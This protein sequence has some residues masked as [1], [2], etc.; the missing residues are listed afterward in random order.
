MLNPLTRKRNSES[1]KGEKCYWH[2]KTG[3]NHSQSKA[4]YCIELNKIWLSIIECSNELGISYGSLSNHLN[5]KSKSA[6]G[7]HFR[8][9]TEE[10]IRKYN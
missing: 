8:F 10:E 7:K 3:N 2:G 1:I 6:G 5:N 9:A 4:V